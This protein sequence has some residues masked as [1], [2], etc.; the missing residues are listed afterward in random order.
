MKVI[1]ASNAYYPS[2][3]GIE[4]SLKHLSQECSF[5]GDS[6]EIIVSDIGLNKYI[7]IENIDNVLIHRYKLKPYN[8]FPFKVF[9]FIFSNIDAI[10]IF[11]KKYKEDPNSI[12]IARFHLSVLQAYIAGFRNIKYVVPSVIK[13]QCSQEKDSNDRFSKRI[14]RAVWTYIH[15]FLQVKAL[16][17]SE[18]YV[19]SNSM[20]KQCI[21][22]NPKIKKI[23]LTKPGVSTTRFYPSILERNE[24]RK[25]LN[26]SENEKV[27]L[28]VGRFVKAKQVDMLIKAFSKLNSGFLILIGKGDE[29]K[30]YIELINNLNISN[31][32]RIIPACSNVEDYYRAA[33]IFAMTSSYEPLGQT[34]IEAFSSGLPVVAF[35][36]SKQVDTAT[37]ELNMNEFIFY[38]HYFSVQSLSESLKKA[39]DSDLNHTSIHNK[40]ALNFSWRSLYRTLNTIND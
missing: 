29:E 6:P 37:E 16:E 38:S 35:K 21:D 17:K 2:I 1:F 13:F 8:K 7:P 5:S 14:K 4:N 26:I 9:N 24:I 27:I 32:V 25:K 40:A 31:R 20:K 36:T 10:K 34:I 28:F 39:L 19:F 30:N 3:G 12:I 18:I 22:I 23:T 33:N 15:T 11:K